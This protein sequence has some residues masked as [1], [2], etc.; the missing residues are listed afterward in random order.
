[1]AALKDDGSGRVFLKRSKESLSTPGA[2][3]FI[4]KIY[5]SRGG[6]TEKLKEIYGAYIDHERRRIAKAKN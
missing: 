4:Q 3:A 5:Q 1:M 2:R 6:P